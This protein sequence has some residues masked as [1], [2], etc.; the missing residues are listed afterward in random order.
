ME[1]E[2]EEVYNIIKMLQSKDVS[3]HQVAFEILNKVDYEKN[4]GMFLIIIKKGNIKTAIL[5]NNCPDLTKKI[6]SIPDMF[7]GVSS[8]ALSLS[9][10]RLLKFLIDNKCSANSLKAYQK[11]VQD[12]VNTSYG[13]FGFDM[14][15]IKFEATLI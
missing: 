7:E 15:K 13:K 10:P 6:L 4:L 1:L 8:F 14:T 11:Y 9:Y 5:R 2:I 12:F 3:N